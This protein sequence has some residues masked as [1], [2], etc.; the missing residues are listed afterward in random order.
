M[1]HWIASSLL[2]VL[3]IPG[4]VFLLERFVEKCNKWFK[5]GKAEKPSGILNSA[6]DSNVVLI[7]LIFF[8]KPISDWLTGRGYWFK[9]LKFTKVEWALGMSAAA[10]AAKSLQLCPTLCNPIDGSPQAPPALGFSRQEHWSGLPFPSPMHGSEKWKWSRVWLFATPW[11]VAY[12][13]SPSM[14]FSRLHSHMF[15]HMFI[16]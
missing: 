5:R 3:P 9:W 14:G 11:T 10:A 15:M 4:Y 16:L 2:K 13:A 8:H 6:S 1:L 7:K 12:Q